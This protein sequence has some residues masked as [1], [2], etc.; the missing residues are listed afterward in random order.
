MGDGRGISIAVVHFDLEVSCS[1]M[2]Q[3]YIVYPSARPD[4]G[5]EFATDLMR[6]FLV[7]IF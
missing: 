3:C 1:G 4:L 2:V 7:F 6:V 5:S